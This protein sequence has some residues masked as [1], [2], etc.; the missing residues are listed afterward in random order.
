MKEYEN[1]TKVQKSVFFFESKRKNSLNKNVTAMEDPIPSKNTKR[2]KTQIITGKL[3]I[4]D[5][6]LCLKN[7]SI[8]LFRYKEIKC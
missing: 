5:N 1:S 8:F 6:L 7:E 4:G 2:G 3:K